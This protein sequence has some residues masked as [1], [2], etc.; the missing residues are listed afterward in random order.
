MWSIHAITSSTI[1]LSRPTGPNDDLTMLANAVVAITI[2][3]FI[4]SINKCAAVVTMNE[5]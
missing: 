3:S 5:K 1:I 2:Q 4:H